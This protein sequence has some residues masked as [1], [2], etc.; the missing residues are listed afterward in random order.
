[1]KI[2]KYINRLMLL[3]LLLAGV[4]SC[5]E[6]ETEQMRS[7]YGYVQFRLASAGTR[8]TQELEYLSDAKKIEVTLLNGDNQITQTLNLTSVDGMGDYGL[9]SEKLELLPGEYKLQSY[10]LYGNPEVAGGDLEVLMQIDLDELIPFQVEVGHIGEVNVDVRSIVRGDVSFLL[11]KDLSVFDEDVANAKKAASRVTEEQSPEEFNYDQIEEVEVYYRKKGTQQQPFVRTMKVYPDAE[12]GLLRTD[13]IPMEANKEYEITQLWMYAADKE[14]LLLAQD[15]NDCYVTVTPNETISPELPIVYSKDNL[16]IKD[17][18]VLYNIWN[19]MGG[20]EWSYYGENAPIG[21]NWRFKNRPVDEWGIQPCVT[22]NNAGRVAQL[23]LGG[24]NPKGAV[25]ESLCDL[26]ELEVLYLGSHLEEGDPN[27][28]TDEMNG[29]AVVDMWKLN[30]DPNYNFKRDYMD[31]FRARMAL[32][33]PS[34]VRTDLATRSNKKS[35][36][37]KFLT[38]VTYDNTSYK[39]T[40]R[41]T[42]LPEN[43]GNLKNLRSLFIAN[44]QIAEL[45]A[46]F[47]ELSGLQECEIYNCTKMTEF[48][49]EQ[50]KGLN[51]VVL[52]FSFNIGISNEK[53]K[54]GLETLFAAGNPICKTLQLLY[55][56]S[57][58]MVDFPT[59]IKNVEDL[60]MLDMSRNRLTTL[61]DLERKF[62]PVQALF[63]D[64]SI[65]TMSDEFCTIDD[66]EELN[67]SNNRLTVFPNLFTKKIADE[68]PNKPSIYPAGT[69]DFSY[70][71]INRFAD[72]FNGVKTETLVLTSNKFD[73]NPDNKTAN[74]KVVFPDALSETKS[75]VQYLQIANCGLDSLSN[76]SVENLKQ[77]VALDCLGNRLRYIPDCFNLETFPYLTG[78]DLSNNAFAQFP[79][80]I[81]NVQALSKLLLASQFEIKKVNGKEVTT[82]CLKK[83]PAN[84]GKHIGLRYLALSGNDIQQISETDFPTQL[85]ELD[86]TENPNLEMTIPSEACTFIQMGRMIVYFDEDQ[87]ILG[88]PA[89]TDN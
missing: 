82:P 65:T 30:H 47:A 49:A 31:V 59:S 46:S 9:T 21:A 28:I 83:F 78:V 11:T 63:C 87:L 8:A 2:L 39:Q 41:I 60:R 85:A 10:T 14:L 56:R 62:R 67:V 72:N 53:Y 81:L 50:L 61:P 89:L 48:P 1:M 68:D 57:N 20:E 17:Y 35:K 79:T 6:D 70:N 38:P 16:A 32:T 27:V 76:S 24:F 15:M 13:T 58:L 69:L 34:H 45:P 77:L 51:L 74:G 3:L 37:K 66:V 40:N 43:I 18:I 88:C 19:K 52:N 33:Y 44:G 4:T 23:D 36:L 86:V 84:I 12:T 29:I 26:S 75:V 64:N 80:N 25:P 5:S 55:L 54:T 71:K 42:A 7:G 22:L 73:E